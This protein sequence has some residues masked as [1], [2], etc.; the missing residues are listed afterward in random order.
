[1]PWLTVCIQCIVRLHLLTGR[2]VCAQGL[3][4][5][6]TQLELSLEFSFSFSSFVSCAFCETCTDIS[7][8]GT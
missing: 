1:M 2:C 3:E 4:K 7:D 6:R 5:N 8:Y